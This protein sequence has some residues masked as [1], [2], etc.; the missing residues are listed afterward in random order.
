MPKTLPC[1]ICQTMPYKDEHDGIWGALYFHSYGTFGSGVYDPMGERNYLKISI[2]D[3]CIKGAADKGLIHEATR[4]P[5]PDDVT[6]KKWHPE[7]YE[8]N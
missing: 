3:K 8:D 4:I 1:I 5:R 6:Y 2:C 7:D